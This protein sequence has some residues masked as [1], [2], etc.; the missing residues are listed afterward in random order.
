MVEKKTA[1]IIGEGL[2]GL[3]CAIR[4]AEAGVFVHLLSLGPAQRS[5]SICAQGGINASLNSK[6]EGDSPL[7][8]AYETIK[9]GD[10]L[11]DQPPIVEMCFSAPKL[12]E[13]FLKK[14][15]P[16]SRTKDGSLDVRQF[17]GSLFSRTL[18]C[19]TTTGMSLV[20]TADQEVHR[21]EACGCIERHE[22]HEFLRLVQ[23]C[24]GAARGII[25]IDTHTLELSY[26]RADV[27]INASGG[28]GTLFK[29]S[30]NSF[31]CTGATNGRLYMQ[32]MYYANGE[33]IQM[34]PTAVPGKDKFR[35]MSE[36]I[37]GE[38]GRIWVYGN[39]SLTITTSDGRTIPCGTTGKPW[40]FLEDLYPVYKNLV[41][42]DIASRE[43]MR[44]YEMGL[45]IDGEKQVYLDV[46]HLPEET[47]KKIE[48]VLD[49][50]QKFTG[51]D[52]R[53]VPMR[54]FPAVHYSM[55]G[56]WV[57]WPAADD[58]DRKARFRQ[59]TNI[60]GSFAIGEADFA[61]H[62]ANRLGANS[63][64]SCIFAGFVAAKECVRYMAK[65]FEKEFPPFEEAL[66]VEE[67]RKQ[68]LL[69]K[70]GSENVYALHNE[71]A[72]L[73]VRNV[74]VQRNNTDLKKTLDAIFT[75]RERY[76][77]ICLSDSSREVNQTLL[78]AHQFEAMIEI[79]LVITKGALLRNESRGSHA[80]E[81]YPERNDAE[82]LKTTIAQYTPEGPTFRYIPVNM[83]Y[84]HP[85]KREYTR[86]DKEPPF[87]TIPQHIEELEIL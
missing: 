5:H 45:G 58:A 29:Q 19:G 30:T 34:H 26:L 18:F 87:D 63:L 47:L 24:D 77:N 33:F 4:L 72:S 37:R 86:M 20:T 12:I 14:G 21:L 13:F 59:M 74:T 25:L 7:I 17:G 82:W 44:I 70:K 9:G 6:H 50:Y 32:G 42:R 67:K 53:Q 40:Y 10:F 52:P 68:E 78:F 71:L 23:G 57:D 56:A 15:C 22:H 84:I 48:G 75:I 54:I 55:G 62:G 1:I 28:L 73:L 65:P 11:G 66:Q 80:K 64:L 83:P 81:D 79:A 60:S 39:S 38:G 43:I 76:K 16:F 46:R 3:T 36:S 27:V 51:E 69:S 31:Y 8:H 61:Y 2:A 41:P 85:T 49:L 35:L